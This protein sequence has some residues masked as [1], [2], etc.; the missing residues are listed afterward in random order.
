MGLR[1]APL[2]P[3]REFDLTRFFARDDELRPALGRV[4]IV[5]EGIR[6]LHL[7]D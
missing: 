2:P 1:S 4:S 7:R 6:I 5:N 3:V